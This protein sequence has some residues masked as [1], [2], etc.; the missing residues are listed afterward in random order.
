[1]IFLTDESG[2]RSAEPD[3]RGSAR[4]R[5]LRALAIALWCAT[6]PLAG[7]QPVIFDVTPRA[8]VAGSTVVINGSGFDPVAEGN[9]VFLGGVR[10]P[11]L[12]ASSTQ[13]S[14]TVPSGSSYGM[15]TVI[16]DGLSATF[17]LPFLPSYRGLGVIDTSSFRLALTPSSIGQGPYRAVAADL[18]GDGR[19]DLG[20][21]NLTGSSVALLRNTVDTL[22]TLG[23]SEDADLSSGFFPED[24][25][26]ADLDG[27][28]RLDIV[29]APRLS[30]YLSAYRNESSAGNL[31]FPSRVDVAS[32]IG[33]KSVA[34]A[35][36]DADGRPDVILTVREDHSVTIY[37]N[38]S[39]PGSIS[40][41]PG[42]RIE[43]RSHP[44]VVAAADADADGR[45]EIFVGTASDD[46]VAAYRV[47]DLMMG[48][49]ALQYRIGCLIE[50]SGLLFGDVN[51]DGHLDML[52]GS[53]AYP[54]LYLFPHTGGTP[55]SS[56]M[57]SI[58]IPVHGPVSEI[59][60]A[61][62][63]ADDRPD[64]AAGHLNA[65]VLTVA[66]NVS[67]TSG[68]VGFDHAVFLPQE[69]PVRGVVAVDLDLNRR[70]DLVTL[71]FLDQKLAVFRN[72][73]STGT[74]VALSEGWNLVSV[75]R[76]AES[77]VAAQLFPGA[78]PGT[79]YGYAEGYYTSEVVLVPG[80]GY[81]AYYPSAAVN[82]IAGDDIDSVIFTVP[83][84]PRWVLFGSVSIARP[85]AELRSVPPDVIEPG[86]LYEFNMGYRPPSSIQPGR[87]YWLFVR[88]PC[89]LILRASN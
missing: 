9:V 57:S 59:A 43:T 75:P 50:P 71:G 36:V 10:A 63:D 74:S 49:V 6:A 25:E 81:W 11:I 35:D 24:I 55:D 37:R 47:V 26:I 7:Q 88:E 42:V 28:A 54:V 53:D 8:A 12:A 23:F 31:F 83:T 70:P 14:V 58:A 17:R 52:V 44:R 18:D 65:S 66:A 68:T 27:D 46:S 19:Q 29:V 78:E 79:I 45:P 62:L 85:V 80:Q 82:T 16:S 61:G 33:G 60:L 40:M 30:P 32:P 73:V 2:V 51:G 5:L 1:M 22:G 4:L 89:T 64:L 3:G 77:Y 87:G 38:T 56:F 13:L 15:V 41:A 39:V 86:T 84:A 67:D 21:V 69:F 72:I 76:R 48:T 34:V 20:V